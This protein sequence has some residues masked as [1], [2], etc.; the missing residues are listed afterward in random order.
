MVRASFL[1]FFSITRFFKFY[2]ILFNYHF[3]FLFAAFFDFFRTH[4]RPCVQVATPLMCTLHLT[5]TTGKVML[6]GAIFLAICNAV[7]AT[8]THCKLLREC[9]AFTVF[10][11]NLQSATWKVFRTL[12]PATSLKPPASKRR[13]LI[14]S[15]SQNCIASCDRHVT[16]ENLSCKKQRCE[17][18]RIVLLS[19]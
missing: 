17:K 4:G 13:V 9:Q 7:M 3:F 18:L 12:S 5:C 6:H 16:N 11:R 8:E 15:F 19:L 14:G 2:F 10:L 1:C